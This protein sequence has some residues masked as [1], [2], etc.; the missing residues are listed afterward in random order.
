MMLSSRPASGFCHVPSGS[1]CLHSESTK[2]A[3]RGTRTCLVS[4]GCGSEGVTRVDP[5]PA[6]DRGP[7]WPTQPLI[8]PAGSAA[9]TG[10]WSLSERPESRPSWPTWPGP[11]WPVTPW[12]VLT[13]LPGWTRSP[14]G[15]SAGTVWSD[16]KAV[17]VPAV[18]IPEAAL[19]PFSVL[20]TDVSDGC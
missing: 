7:G 4:D 15:G 20:Q 11:A 1:H 13:G 5:T 12:P 3:A 18:R 10:P 6:R 19:C 16:S 14:G 17:Y 8:G 2:K 9:H